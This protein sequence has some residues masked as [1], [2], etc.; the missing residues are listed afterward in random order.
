MAREPTKCA[1]M[2][3]DCLNIIPKKKRKIVIKFV[4]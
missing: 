2:V 3:S 4:R 1:A